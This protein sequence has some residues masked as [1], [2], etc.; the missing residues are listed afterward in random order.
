[1]R[2]SLSLSAVTGR[3]FRLENIRAGRSQPGLRPQHLLAVRATAALCSAEL[4]GDALNSTTL[5]FR[6]RH[7]ARA[8]HYQF[9]VNEHTPHSSAGS[10]T[11]VWQTLI[12]PLL[13]ADGP[14]QLVLRGGTHVPFS[15]S[16]DYVNYVTVPTYR[17][18]GLPLEVSLD[19][20]GWMARGGGEMTADITPIRHITPI[21][22]SSPPS[23][24][25]LQGEAVAT[26]LP[27]H[28]PQRM[29]NRA[30][31][32]LRE[33][34]MPTN[35]RPVRARSTAEGATILLWTDHAGFGCLGE[36]GLP[37]QTVAERAV[38]EAVAFFSS[39]TAVDVHLADQLL[40]PLSLATGTSRFTTSE[41]TLHTRTNAELLRLWL[42]V[43]IRFEGQVVMVEG[44]GGSKG[45]G[46][47]GQKISCH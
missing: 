2:T 17:Q 31:N 20:W 42:G 12:W 34:G 24:A 44:R 41:I 14:S 35:V 29:A 18:L 22:L 9:D 26:N 28:I 1:M 13:F 6:P 4:V 32:L 30:M 37:A 33:A 27:V 36:K 7:P 16:F 45:G 3:P 5:E 39:G 47:E 46:V 15:P 43:E 23:P 38:D 25:N 8:G 11:L 40:I 19:E 21:E 10:V